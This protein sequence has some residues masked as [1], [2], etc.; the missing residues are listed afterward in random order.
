MIPRTKLLI[1][2]RFGA[3]DMTELIFL[4]V[5]VDLELLDVHPRESVVS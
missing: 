4:R 2:V 5:N 3:I 1:E